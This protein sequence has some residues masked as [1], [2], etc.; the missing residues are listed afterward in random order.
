MIELD[1]YIYTTNELLQALWSVLHYYSYSFTLYEAILTVCALV[2]VITLPL[3]T[4]YTP[5]THTHT[6]TQLLPQYHVTQFGL[7]FHYHRQSH[8]ITASM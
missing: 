5:H 8:H 3:H 7:L 2:N 4:L 6:P 1:N